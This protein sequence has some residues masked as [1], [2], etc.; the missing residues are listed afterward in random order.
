[1]YRFCFVVFSVAALALASAPGAFA[2]SRSDASQHDKPPVKYATT[3][4]HADLSPIMV[5]GHHMPF[6]AVLQLYKKALARHWSTKPADRDKLVCQWHTPVGTRLQFL[7]CTTNKHH[8][9]EHRNIQAAV[10]GVI[11]PG[12]DPIKEGGALKRGL[13]QGR[14]PV[15]LANLASGEQLSRSSLAPMLAKLPGPNATYTLRVTGDNGKP[16]VDYVIRDGDLAHV[17]RYVYKEGASTGTR[18]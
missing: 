7:S 3:Q 11:V 10:N 18:Q 14:I 13:V 9:R 15:Q 2:L 4:S 6:V 16:L 1:M 8:F 17:Y 12:N 5:Y